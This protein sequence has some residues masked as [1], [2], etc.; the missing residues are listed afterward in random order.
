MRK[1]TI[2]ILLTFL[3]VKA[4]GQTRKLPPKDTYY[5][6]SK[7]DCNFPRQIGKLEIIKNDSLQLTTYKTD[8]SEMIM[9]AEHF[10]GFLTGWDNKDGA[11]KIY[12]QL[13]SL[14][15]LL[16]QNGLMTP[17]LLIKAF[18]VE[19][20]YIDFKGDTVD[21][22]NHIETKTIKL[23]NIQRKKL[24]KKY[25]DKKGTILFEVWVTFNPYEN[26]W[27]SFPMFDLYFKSDIELTPSNLKDYLKKAKIKCLRYTSTQI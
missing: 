10:S 11:Q 14:V 24:P 23:L 27:G 16:F 26:G 22:T 13:D 25:K 8:S 3:S 18:N 15:T 1:K 20:K 21:F 5:P 6:V 7:M 17:D 19:S 9:Y 4:F 12:L 2:I